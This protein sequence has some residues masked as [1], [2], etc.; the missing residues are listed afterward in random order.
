MLH[1]G[2]ARGRVRA[3]EHRRGAGEIVA[4]AH[5]ALAAVGAAHLAERRVAELSGGELQR[6]CL[7]SALALEP[8]LLLLDE[9]TSQLDPEARRGV[10]RARRAARSAVVVSEQ[11]PVAVLG[12][13]RPRALPRAGADR[14]WTRRATRRS[15]G[16]REHRPAWLP[17]SRAPAAAAAAGGAVCRLDGVSFAYGDGTPWSRESPR[18]RRGEIV[19]LAGPNGTGRRRSRSSPPGCSSRARAP[20]SVRGRARLPL[21]GPGRYLVASARTRRSRSGWAAICARAREALRARASP[22]SRPAIHETSRAASANGSPSPRCSS[23]IPTC[24]CWTSPRAAS[25]PSARPSWPLSCTSR[26]HA[27]H[28]RRHARRGVRRG[29]RRPRV[30]TA[31]SGR[32]PLSRVAA[33]RAVAAAFAAAAWTA[34][35]PDDAG[36]G[37][38]AGRGRARRRRRVLARERPGLGKEL[39]VDRDAGRGRGRG[40]GSVRRR[41]RVSSR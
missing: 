4:R 39:V 35:R 5:E 14:C 6:V 29:R 37:A 11:R 28:A 33:L 24:S 2:R 38:A 25:T 41:S 18:A 8:Q 30:S 36:A 31:P 16:S 9:P 10:H 27:R 22:G 40:A 17:A 26:A 32:R 23:P 20:S 13:L 7:A 34:P 19:A 12:R 21:A 3:R 15:G 1:A